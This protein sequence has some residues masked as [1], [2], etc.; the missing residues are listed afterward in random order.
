MAVKKIK[1]T[2]KSVESSFKEAE[3]VASELDKGIFKKRIPTISFENFETYKRLLTPRRLELLQVIKANSPRT[4]QE[5]ASVSSRDFKNVYEDVKILKIIGLI[6]LKKSGPG[7][8]PIVKYTEID[9]H[10]KIPLEVP[11]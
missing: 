3:R 1:I 5:L 10:I 8:T 11:A 2:I 9:M 6:K 7:L 4:I